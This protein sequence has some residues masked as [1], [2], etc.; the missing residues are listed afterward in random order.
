LPTGGYLIAVGVLTVL[1]LIVS[2][3]RLPSPA[4]DLIRV[5]HF[6]GKRHA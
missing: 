6:G 3:V 1:A 2:T 5:A 4:I